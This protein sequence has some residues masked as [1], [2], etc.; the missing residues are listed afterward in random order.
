M[1][2]IENSRRSWILRSVV[3]KV[4]CFKDAPR[5]CCGPNPR[6]CIKHASEY[7]RPD[8]ERGGDL[9]QSERSERRSDRDSPNQ[10]NTL[11]NGD[12]HIFVGWV[13]GT[14]ECFFIFAL[15]L[16]PCLIV[17]A[18]SLCLLL[19]PC[20]PLS[21]LPV[22]VLLCWLGCSWYVLRVRCALPVPTCRTA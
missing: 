21:V 6:G 9:Y 13:G 16:V 18:W 19:L 14:P 17:L 2:Y 10:P 11:R 15:A 5:G 22:F 1:Q 7:Q 20:F 12:V 3:C 4:L 8:E